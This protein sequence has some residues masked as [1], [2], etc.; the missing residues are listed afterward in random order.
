[1]HAEEPRHRA[2]EPRRADGTGRPI[3]DD[4]T[5]IET[6]A[7]RLRAPA[8]YRELAVRALDVELAEVDAVIR[9]R[10][11]RPA[12]EASMGTLIEARGVGR[13]WHCGTSAGS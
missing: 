3:A 7:R 8:R 9:H 12:L 13:P 5:E 2:N 11:A 1:V 10:K 6:A 4:L